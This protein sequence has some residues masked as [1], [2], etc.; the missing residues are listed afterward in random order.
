MKSKKIKE[1]GFYSYS[2]QQTRSLLLASKDYKIKI[3]IFFKYYIASNLG[4]IW[5][6]EV[7]KMLQKEFGRKKFNIVIDC[8]QNTG[9]ALNSIRYGF[10]YIKFNGNITIKKKIA[11]IRYKNKILLNPNIK[12]FDLKKIKNYEEYIKKIYLINCEKVK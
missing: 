1:L 9:L 7:N 12:L 2:Y 10:N 11:N 5:I 3:F 4:V 6:S 8:R